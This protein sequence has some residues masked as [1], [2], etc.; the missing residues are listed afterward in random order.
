MTPMV[1]TQVYLRDEEL[2][3][4]HKVAE[5]S[6]RSVADLVRE[7]IRRVW[8]RPGAQ[9]PVALWDGPAAHTSIEHD[10]IYDA[11]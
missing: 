9:G 3:A 11:P 6:G 4:L 5:R 2:K 10:H 8:L 1:K 7:A